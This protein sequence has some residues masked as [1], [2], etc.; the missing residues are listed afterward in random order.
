MREA[1]G[2]LVSAAV[3][4]RVSYMHAC[5][6]YVGAFTVTTFIK[7]LTICVF[8]FLYYT[9]IKSILKKFCCIHRHM[10]K[11]QC[12]IKRRM[13]TRMNTVVPVGGERDGEMDVCTAG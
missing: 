8:S 12:E 7:L 3:H 9:A 2:E 5:V 6:G 10:S 13:Q 11:V 1:F 4:P